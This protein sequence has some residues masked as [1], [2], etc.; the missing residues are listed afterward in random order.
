MLN[1]K[2]I[3]EQKNL[4]QDDLVAKTGIP[5][6]SYVSYENGEADIQLSKLLKIASVLEVTI[7]DLAGDSKNEKK[8]INSDD[9]QNDNF[10]DTIP[11]VK[12]KLSI[13]KE[14]ESEYSAVIRKLK[15]SENVNLSEQGAPFYP[16]PVSAGTVAE[17]TKEK[18][19]PTGFISMP[20]VSCKAYFPV[21]GCSF[22][23]II[24]AGDI[25]GVDFINKWER[26]DPDC[27]YFIITHD[28]RMIKRLQDHPEDPEKLLCISPNYKDF[29]IW[30]SEI[31]VIHKVVFY[32]RLV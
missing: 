31:K 5:K 12:E 20:G 19:E 26:L 10:I 11:K 32:G 21:V 17:L 27:I 2:R 24:K 30:K 23:D 1:I 16:L 4:T 28:Q 22:S 8:V 15:F 14:K 6:R 18:A 13:V 9:N 7:S 29:P 25:I 3:R